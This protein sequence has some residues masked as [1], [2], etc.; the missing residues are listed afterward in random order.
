MNGH[1]EDETPAIYDSQMTSMAGSESERAYLVGRLAQGV[2]LG[3]AI[4]DCLESG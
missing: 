3:G 1:H 2:W 4:P